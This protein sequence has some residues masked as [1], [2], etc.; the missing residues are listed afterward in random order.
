MNC[1]VQILSKEI[2]QILHY[3]NK[4]IVFKLEKLIFLKGRTM[5]IFYIKCL[6]MQTYSLVSNS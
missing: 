6:N 5:S 1:D 3:Y 4:T 2:A